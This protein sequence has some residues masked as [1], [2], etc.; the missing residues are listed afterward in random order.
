MNFSKVEFIKSAAAER[1]FIRDGRP[2]ITFAG[3]S[4]VGKSSLINALVGRRN[5][6][7]VG[8]EPGK[9]A[10]VNYFL[11][12]G[13]AYIT[14]L[15]GYGYAR[16]S[17]AERDRWG[18]LMESYFAEPELITLGVM[19]VDARHRPSADDVTMAEWFIGTGCPF[20]VAANKADKCKRSEIEGSL[21]VIRETLS[22]PPETHVIP[23]SAVTGA[24]RDELRIEIEKS[25]SL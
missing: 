22:L 1:D 7:R 13:S 4:N 19:I 24:G 17:K 2:Q 15:P 3:R 5:M 8:A 23:C 11:I 6:A 12:D 18:R 20:I 25:L 14:D 21:D 9:T 16:V 10:H